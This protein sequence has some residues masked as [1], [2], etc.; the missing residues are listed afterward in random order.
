M[1]ILSFH[2]DI[3]EGAFFDVINTRFKVPALQITNAVHSSEVSGQKSITIVCNCVR[4]PVRTAAN[5]EW[6]IKRDCCCFE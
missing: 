2:R 6:T 4:P 3:L 5:T 1:F